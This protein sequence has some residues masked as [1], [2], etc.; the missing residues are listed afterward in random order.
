M[1]LCRTVPIEIA[2]VTANARYIHTSLALR[3]L[4]ANLGDF[5]SRTT[6]MEFTIDE[7]PADIAEKVLR[8][9]PSVVLLAF[10]IWNTNLL[11]EAASL[12]RRI[13]PDIRIV[14]GGPEVSFFPETHPVFA[15]V[16]CIVTGEAESVISRIVRKL[17]RGESLESKIIAAPLPD[18]KTIE[19][20]YELYTNEDI[21]HRILYIETSRGCPRGCEFCLSSLD[22]KVRKFPA[23][24]ILDALETLWQR[25]A[26]QFKFVDRALHLTAAEALLTFFL[27]KKD[28]GIFLHFELIP[29]RLSARLFSLLKQFPKGCVQVEAGIQT[30]NKEVSARINRKQNI[31]KALSTLK[32]LREETGVHI[33][34]D[35]VAGLPGESISSFA[36]GFDRLYALGLHEIQVGILK[37][38]RGAPIARHD[39]EWK[40][41]YNENPPYD[42]LQTAHVDFEAMQQ[43]KRF[44]KFFDLVCNRGNFRL[45][46]PRLLQ[47][48]ASSFERLMHLSLRLYEK[49]GRSYGIALNR[50]ADLL[51]AYAEE[52][53]GV[54]LLDAKELIRQSF[55]LAGRKGRREKSGGAG[56]LPSRQKRHL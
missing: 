22:T 2:A 52:E 39:D 43:M 31:E 37:K 33:H 40:M 51:A 55:E 48:D 15:W 4:A 5:R 10:Y 38:L 49:V 1:E 50:L 6:L 20:P 16:D 56:H 9:N 41:I 53:K 13:R 32:A 21:R 12:I 30:L 8:L 23:E 14:A 34:A 28:A 36:A 3:S 44:A 54:S 47:G 24:K 26:R 45:L 35:L 17:T 19:L 18:L 25:G 29:D 27:Q 11:C 46:V 42:I 7:K